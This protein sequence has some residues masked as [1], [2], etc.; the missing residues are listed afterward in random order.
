MLV[1]EATKA[2]KISKPYGLRG[3]VNIILLPDARNH[4]EP[5][6]PLFID[7]D[8]QR[9]PF[10]IEEVELVSNDQA[11]VK[12]E[13]IDSLE[14]AREVSGCSIY[15][16]LQHQPAPVEDGD[17][18]SNLIGY[19]ASDR[20]SGQL[21]KISDYLPHPLNPMFVIQSESKELMVPAARDFIDH[22]NPE[23]Q[24]VQFILPVGLTSL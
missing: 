9:V 7:I 12:F 6:N 16:D 13:F 18:L 11:I 1:P 10:F 4:I 23:E 20:E 24:S 3:E 22:I 2:G 19:T 17:D 14:A 21:G 5:D 8:G 15:F